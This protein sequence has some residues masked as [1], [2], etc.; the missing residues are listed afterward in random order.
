MCINIALH[1]YKQV[2]RRK[3]PVGSHSDS[4]PQGLPQRLCHL[5]EMP[6]KWNLGVTDFLEMLSMETYII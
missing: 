1:V 5:Q 2:T 3:L 4:P 6:E